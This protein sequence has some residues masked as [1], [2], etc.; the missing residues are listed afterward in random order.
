MAQPLPQDILDL[1]RDTCH[2]LIDEAARRI[3]EGRIAPAHNE[4][5]AAPV[6]PAT[7]TDLQAYRERRRTGVA[8]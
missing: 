7:V 4:A 2:A 8:R 3:D 5:S 6:L 1:V